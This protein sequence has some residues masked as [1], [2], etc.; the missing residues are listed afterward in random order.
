MMINS[1]G[2]ELS[3][4]TLGQDISLIACLKTFIFALL[5]SLVSIIY[6]LRLFKWIALR[7]HTCN[8]G[9]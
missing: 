4:K 6:L 3:E 1:S 8:M 5:N 9:R 7:S 2:F